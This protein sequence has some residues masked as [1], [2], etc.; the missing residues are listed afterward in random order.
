MITNKEFGPHG[1]KCPHCGNSAHNK[2]PPG[3][4][5][6]LQC[7]DCSTIWEFEPNFKAGGKVTHAGKPY[8]VIE[9]LPQSSGAPIRF[10]LA[11]T[12][13]GKP[14]L[15]VQVKDCVAAD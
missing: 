5:N 1:A 9:V 12:P 15:N 3:Y 2:T 10:K 4:P 7:A 6:L 13:N 11:K 14:V 8:H